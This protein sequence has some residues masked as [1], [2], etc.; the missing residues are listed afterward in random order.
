MIFRSPPFFS[1][2]IRTV[3]TS[4]VALVFCGCTGA[5]GEEWWQRFKRPSSSAERDRL[6]QEMA[7]NDGLLQKGDIIATDRGFLVFRGVGPDGV[8]NRFEPVANPFDRPK[9]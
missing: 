2:V 4:A 1:T 8:T 5:S 6:N 9:R 3:L 7:R